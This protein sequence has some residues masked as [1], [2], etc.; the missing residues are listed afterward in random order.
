MLSW[1]LARTKTAQ[2]QIAARNIAQQD[3][4]YYLPCFIET[5]VIRGRKQVKAAPLFPSYI[6]VRVC[7]LRY[8]F[9]NS[10]NG[11]YRVLCFGLSPAIV[12][13]EDIKRLMRSEQDGL[14]VLPSRQHS[15]FNRNERVRVLAGP[16]EDQYGLFLEH[17]GQ[18]RV[19]IL[20]DLL[21]RRTAVTLPQCDIERAVPA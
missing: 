9:L 5:K 16:F 17:T 21:K 19:R 15:R 20:L 8:L 10:T 3:H 12:P 14:V 7:N 6:F 4:E 18:E 1:V 13:D 2:E 11:I